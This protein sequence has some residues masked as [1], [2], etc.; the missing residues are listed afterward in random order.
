MML[1]VND[2][3]VAQRDY[4]YVDLFMPPELRKWHLDI[5]SS[6]IMLI[7]LEGVFN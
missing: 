7:S 3:L 5:N 2:S 1:R 6:F 4:E